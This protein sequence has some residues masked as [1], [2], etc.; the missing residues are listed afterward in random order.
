M[1]DLCAI[2][3]NIN[4]PGRTFKQF[5]TFYRSFCLL[6]LCNISHEVNLKNNTYPKQIRGNDAKLGCYDSRLSQLSDHRLIIKL[7]NNFLR[8][9]VIY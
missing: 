2:R 3:Q 5:V 8:S 7:W 6:E 4:R 9:E 1:K